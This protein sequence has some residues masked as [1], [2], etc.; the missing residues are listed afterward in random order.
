MT[1]HSYRSHMEYTVSDH[2][3]VAAR[4]LLQVSPGLIR[5]SRRSLAQLSIF[6]Q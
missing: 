5:P 1:Q 4:F 3:P 6:Y 2:K